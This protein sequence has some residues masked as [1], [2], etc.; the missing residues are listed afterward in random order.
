MAGPAQV[1]VEIVT[2]S[3]VIDKWNDPAQPPKISMNGEPFQQP[4]PPATA[5]GWQLVVLDSS[6]DMT[7]PAAIRYNSFLDLFAD[8]NGNWFDTYQYMYDNI[9]RQVLLS[10]DPQTQLVFLVSYGLDANAPPT[11][12]ALG[13]MLGAGA[14]QQLQ[15]W[16]RSVDIGSEGGWTSFPACY[17]MIGG[18]SYSYDQG[19]EVYSDQG[20]AT[21]SVTLNNPV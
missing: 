2:T 20:T 9:V 12:D 1:T 7:D 5:T 19:H 10:G 15:T 3:Q 11:T 21:L 16:E 17:I 6:M 14:G 4:A 13:Y 18:S 8:Q